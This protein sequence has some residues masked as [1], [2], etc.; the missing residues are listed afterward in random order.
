MNQK[1]LTHV[2]DFISRGSCLSDAAFDFAYAP[3][4]PAS[5]AITFEEIEGLAR[6]AFST[7]RGKFS[8][9]TS[10]SACGEATPLPWM[11]TYVTGTKEQTHWKPVGEE[12][13]AIASK[14]CASSNEGITPRMIPN[15]FT[16]DF[17]LNTSKD[18]VQHLSVATL[19]TL[20]KCVD[21]TLDCNFG[22]AL[23][24]LSWAYKF[25]LEIVHIASPIAHQRSKSCAGAVASHATH[26]KE[27]AKYFEWLDMNR[28]RFKS[29]DQTA[30]NVPE[31]IVAKSFRTL[32]T[33]LDEWEKLRS[34]GRQ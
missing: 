27:K 4:L 11:T 30:A 16:P 9:E 20:D 6:Y 18:R 3:G 19:L 21:L 24:W 10:Y 22:E 14:L 29:K 5:V 23:Q 2:T 28:G 34:T 31:K 1:T 7:F 8:V 17:L 15:C 13:A 26:R 12:V 33:W 25:H 32:R